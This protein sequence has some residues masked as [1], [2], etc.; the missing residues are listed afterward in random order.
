[1]RQNLEKLNDVLEAIEQIEKYRQKGKNT[2]ES[3]ELIQVWMLHYLQIR[4]F[5]GQLL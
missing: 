4:K 2:F 1:M 3:D 5:P